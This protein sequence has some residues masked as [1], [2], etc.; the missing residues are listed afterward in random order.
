MLEMLVDEMPRSE[1]SLQNGIKLLV[2]RTGIEPVTLGLRV[3]I[4]PFYTCCYLSSIVIICPGLMR[5]SARSVSS[6]VSPS[7]HLYDR[8][9][10]NIAGMGKSKQ[11]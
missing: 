3:L 8:V 7:H 11:S 9:H 5:Y 1:I 2:G 6:P 10:G 4:V